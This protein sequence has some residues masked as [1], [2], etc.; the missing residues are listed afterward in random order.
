VVSL[1]CVDTQEAVGL[2]REQG[3]LDDAEASG[4]AAL[5]E[6]RRPHP[7][8]TRFLTLPQVAEELATSTAQIMALVRRGH[9][10]AIELDGRG[11]WRVER[12]K[13]E[14]FIARAYDDAARAAHRGT[15]SSAMTPA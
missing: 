1:I 12:S 13:L 3:L 7:G 5:P 8:A 10:P 2:A 15:E 9:L 6:Q 14:E 4:V 11:Q